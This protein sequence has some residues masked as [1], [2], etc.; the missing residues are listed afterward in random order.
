MRHILSN[1]YDDINTLKCYLPVESAC[2][3]L[4]ACLFGADITAYLP[5]T[6]ELRKLLPHNAPTPDIAPYVIVP[7]LGPELMDRFWKAAG[8]NPIDDIPKNKVFTLN[9]PNVPLLNYNDVFC[10]QKCLLPTC[11]VRKVLEFTME[12]YYDRTH[13]QFDFLSA[14]IDTRRN[15]TSYVVIYCRYHSKCP[16]HSVPSSLQTYIRP[17]LPKPFRTMYDDR[18]LVD[19][20]PYLTHRGKKGLQV[21]NGWM[22]MLL[23]K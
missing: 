14:H 23:K 10:K 12:S 1:T 16:V 8:G 21:K 3:I 7:N 2:F 18:I 6:E 17:R 19:Y 13:A 15:G 5:N 4:Q 22:S 11:N 20:T 9:S